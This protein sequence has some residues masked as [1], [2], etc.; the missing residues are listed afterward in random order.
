M[1]SLNYKQAIPSCLFVFLFFLSKAQVNLVTNPSFEDTIGT[2]AYTGQGRVA[3]W[4]NLDSTRISISPFVSFSTFTLNSYKLPSNSW[5]YQNAR[6]GN[7]VISILTYYATP[8]L[9]NYYRSFARVKLKSPLIAGGQYCARMHVNPFETETYFTNGISMYFDNGQLDTIVAKDSSGIY[10]FVNPQV[11]CGFIVDDT[12]NWKVLEG[13]FTATGNET[14][15]TVG[16]F[17]SNLNT[18]KSFCNSSESC[19]CSE[20]IIDDVSVIEVNVSNWLHDTTMVLGDSVYIGLPMYEVPDA[21]WYDINMNYIGKGS[22]IKVKPNQWF[23]QYIQSIDVCSS[24]RYDTMTVWAAPLSVNQLDNLAMEQYDIYPNPT[25]GVFSILVNESI[26][27]ATLRI[28]NIT[29]ETIHQSEGLIGKRFMFDISSE[30]NGIYFVEIK[31]DSGI[32]RM[33]LVKE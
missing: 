27:N 25:L 26:M 24:I 23:T 2:A 11:Q 8:I 28:F 30:A 3:Y 17:L 7:V 31:T 21:L 13:L 12:L 5:F 32:K 14:F 10:P 29:G 9:Q 1:I 19:L 18:Q 4:N 15:L 33:K 20:I 6:N 22:G 16:N